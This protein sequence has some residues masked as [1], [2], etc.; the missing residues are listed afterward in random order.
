VLAADVVSF[1]PSVGD[2]QYG[3]DTKAS[4]VSNEYLAY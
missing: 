3:A 2:R 4:R 1:E